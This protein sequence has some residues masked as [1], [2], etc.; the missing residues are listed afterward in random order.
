MS[1]PL[2]S[3]VICVYNGARFLTATIDSVL[4]QTWRDFDVV[5]VDDGSFDE[6]VALVRRYNGPRV[7]LLTQ[8]NQ[9][10]AA[11]LAAGIRESKGEF[12]AMLDQ[13]D[14]W[15]K[16]YLWA[17]MTVQQQP[18]GVDLT[19]SWV[20]VINESGDP[21]GAHS[22]RQREPV[23]F[24]DLLEDFVIGGSSNVVVRRAAIEK[25]G[26]VDLAIGGLYDLD[27]CLR[28]ALL[29]PHNIQPVPADLMFYRRHKRQMTGDI[30]SLQEQWERVIAKMIRRAPEQAAPRLQRARSNNYRYYGRL[31]YEAGD[32]T[33]CLDFLRKGSVSAPW[34]FLTDSRNWITLAACLCGLLLPRRAHRALE[35]MAGLTI[36]D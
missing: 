20:Q 5:I 17:H 7:R 19:F 30:R 8:T 24:G 35:R 34:Y 3:V 21:I 25:A 26:G 29:R 28:I 2:V 12:V 13:D 36:R 27:L 32:F 6:S 14:L 22:R 10:T 1:E 18:D 9:G 33:V 15:H 4:A 11:A 16:D 31:A 23:D